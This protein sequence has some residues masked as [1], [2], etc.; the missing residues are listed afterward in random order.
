MMDEITVQCICSREFVAPAKTLGQTVP[1]PNCGRPVR[2]TAENVIAASD[3]A[4]EG[5]STPAPV[6]P[7]PPRQLSQAELDVSLFL[8]DDEE[9]APRSQRA[10]ATPTSPPPRGAAV[11]VGAVSPKPPQSSPSPAPV[12]GQGNATRAAEPDFSP[13]VPKGQRAE[14]KVPRCARCNRP[15]RGPWDQID[16]DEGTLCNI[17]ARHIDNIVPGSAPPSPAAAAFGEQSELYREIARQQSWQM[18]AVEQAVESARQDDAHRQRVQMAIFAGVAVLT[19][20]LILV[21]PESAP[22]PAAPVEETR[23]LP[24]AYAHTIV[25]INVLLHIA[26]YAIA[27]YCALLMAK[28]LPNDSLFANIAAVTVVAVLV[29]AANFMPFAGFIIGAVIIYRFYE[30]SVGQFVM[31]WIFLI[32]A[33]MLT[34]ALGALIFGVMSMIAL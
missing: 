21:W 18:P 19:L 29:W 15:F 33:H 25:A 16:T 1:C 11:T 5:Q 23:E 9:P 6:P 10:P 34:R 30:L 12:S 32:L 28:R 20:L 3:G 24:P 2:V 26:T 22:R 14:A 27:I 13:F 31:L 7:E 8:D 4:D 17:C